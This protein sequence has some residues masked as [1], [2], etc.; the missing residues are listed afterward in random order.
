[1]DYPE[2]LRRPKKS[3]SSPRD[4]FRAKLSELEKQISAKYEFLAHTEKDLK[5]IPE[6]FKKCKP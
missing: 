2:L 3:Y 6:R 4:T 5:L 1:M